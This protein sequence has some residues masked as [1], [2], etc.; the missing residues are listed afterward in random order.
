M[1]IDWAAVHTVALKRA[2]RESDDHDEAD[3]VASMVMARMFFSGTEIDDP[4]RVA[5]VAAR[6]ALLDVRKRLHTRH[7][8]PW[9]DGDDAV[10]ETADP[11][12]ALIA[13]Q[14]HATR[15]RALRLALRALSPADRQA[16]R[17][18][19]LRGVP[20]PEVARALR[21]TEGA[22]KMRLIRARHAMRATLCP[23]LTS[24]SSSSCPS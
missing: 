23:L 8:R 9:R 19:H 1:T 14:E 24:V 3:D 4:Q 6:N 22:M 2:R 5:Y 11:L 21:T 16:V 20:V 15:R 10:D 7:E 18:Y 12:A 13:A 17:L